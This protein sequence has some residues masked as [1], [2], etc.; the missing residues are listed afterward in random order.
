MLPDMNVEDSANSF[1]RTRSAF[2]RDKLCTDDPG[3]SRPSDIVCLARIAWFSLI[4]F[5]VAT[6]SNSLVPSDGGGSYPRP[7][8]TGLCAASWVIEENPVAD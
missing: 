1:M 2:C 5:T 8:E 6:P 7:E 4:S 3:V